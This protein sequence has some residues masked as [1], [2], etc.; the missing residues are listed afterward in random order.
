M[1]IGFKKVEYRDTNIRETSR[2]L[3]LQKISIGRKNSGKN[4][5]SSMKVNSI[6][7]DLAG[8]IYVR[9]CIGEECAEN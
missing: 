8:R 2:D 7:W 9:R 5:Y 6:V 3:D 1:R 4:L